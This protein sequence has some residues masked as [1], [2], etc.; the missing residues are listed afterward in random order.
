MKTEGRRTV[1]ENLKLLSLA[2][3]F[4]IFGFWLLICLW[5]S[6]CWAV[7]SKVTRHSSSVDLL[8]GQTEDIVV[9]SEGTIQL[10][11]AAEALVEK[12][13]EVS[14]AADVKKGDLELLLS[15]KRNLVC[16]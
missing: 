6:A 5:D 15:F 8:R 2:L 7:T 12:F 14:G 10:G 16:R 9:S 11:R 1:V 3:W 4:Y 13:E